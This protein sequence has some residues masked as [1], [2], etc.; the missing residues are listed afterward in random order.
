MKK[1]VEDYR[2]NEIV[3]T[4]ESTRVPAVLG[5]FETE[6]DARV[7]MSTNLLAMGSKLTTTRYMDDFELEQIR[8]EYSEE[9]EDVLPRYKSDHMKKLEDLERA[10]QV[11]KEA[12]EMVNAS[13]NKIQQLAAE[14]NERI[15]EID[16]DP[17]VTW[18]V[19]YDGKRYY[20][21]LIDAELKLAKVR[22]IPQF[23]I[24]DLLTSC[25]KNAIYFDRLKKAANE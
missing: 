25:D 12:K 18:E 24:E 10:K 15:T 22:E 17:S 6:E 11:E 7:F 19:P 23:E 13:L 5:Q 1:V 21:T 16:L 2:P 20:Y 14:A 9:L 4:A 8:D 3:F